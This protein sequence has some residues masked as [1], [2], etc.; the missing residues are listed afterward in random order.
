MQKNNYP[1]INNTVIKNLLKEA[2]KNKIKVKQ[3]DQRFLT[4]CL[5]YKD[6]RHYFF[7]KK[8]GLNT[9]NASLVSNKY[10]T[11]EILKKAG[12]SVPKTFLCETIEDT[13][14]LIKQKKIKYP[15]VIK[16]YDY[17]LGVAVTANITDEQTIRLAL[18]RLNR[19]WSKAKEW[20]KKKKRQIFL[21]EEHVQGNDY[22]ILVLNN[23]VIAATQRAYPEI[24]G[25]GKKT[26]R[27]LIL[28]Y[29]KNHKYYQEKKRNPLIDDELR[30]NLKQQKVNFKTVLKKG[31]II[32]LRQT[33]NVF[34]GGIS[35]NI[36][37]KINPYYK[38]IAIQA[39]QEFNL[40][41]AGID[42]MTKDISKNGDYKII[43]INSFP[44]LDMHE[45]PDIGKPI[46]VSKLI[47]K[48]IFPGLK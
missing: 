36:T 9:G 27:Q 40:N 32:R 12:L 41:L 38:K 33:A 46:N 16:P 1:K 35:V 6:K 3:I 4:F 44:A 45:N 2:K 30:R 15:F 20:G 28:N 29:Y 17:S 10:L 11:L 5:E 14:K 39:C 7:H 24:I 22:R 48:S 42:L 23:K 21:V 31:Q 13:K 34:G 37:D 18:T 8:I 26:V 19:Y 43:E 25:D 47:L